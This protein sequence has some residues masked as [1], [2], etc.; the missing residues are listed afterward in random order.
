MCVLLVASEMD[1]LRSCMEGVRLLQHHEDDLAT[2]A[3]FRLDKAT[4]PQVER[5]VRHVAQSGICDGLLYLTV[6]QH[7]DMHLART[8]QHG[9]LDGRSRC[10]SLLF[11]I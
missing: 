5:T 1:G 7:G 2:T 4:L 9:T 10:F 6:F 8:I 3:M 11:A